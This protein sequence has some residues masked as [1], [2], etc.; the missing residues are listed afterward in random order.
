MLAYDVGPVT[1]NLTYFP[2]ISGVNQVS[3]LGF[4]VNVWPKRW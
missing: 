2:K 4:W 3:A 1:L